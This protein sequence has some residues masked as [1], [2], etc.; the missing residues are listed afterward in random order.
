MQYENNKHKIRTIFVKSD[1][2]E[3][4]IIKKKEEQARLIKKMKSSSMGSMKKD[5]RYVSEWQI[6]DYSVT[7]K[8]FAFLS[9]KL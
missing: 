6:M 8:Y 4:D 1:T 9:L 7:D 2:S 3:N 5:N